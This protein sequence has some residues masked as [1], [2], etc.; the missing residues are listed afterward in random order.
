MRASGKLIRISTAWLYDFGT[1]R[2]G[3][4]SELCVYL[5]EMTL[6]APLVL[7]PTG[8][9]SEATYGLFNLNVPSLIIF[10]G[11]FPVMCTRKHSSTGFVGRRRNGGTGVAVDNTKMRNVPKGG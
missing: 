1:S 9:L 3:W 4:Y 11:R 5:S 6:V 8:A 2:K 7:S 10:A